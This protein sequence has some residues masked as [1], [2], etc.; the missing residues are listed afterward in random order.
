MV[1]LPLRAWHASNASFSPP[2]QWLAGKQFWMPVYSIPIFAGRKIS[3]CG[4]GWRT[5]A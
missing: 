1:Q 5:A 4:Y 3:I 2:S